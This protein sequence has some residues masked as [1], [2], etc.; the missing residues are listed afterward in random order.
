MIWQRVRGA[1]AKSDMTILRIDTREDRKIN[2][3]KKLIRCR[4]TVVM[5]SCYVDP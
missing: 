2:L 5:G 1:L 4:D 3:F